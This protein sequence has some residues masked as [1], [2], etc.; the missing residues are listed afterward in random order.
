MCSDSGGVLLSGIFAIS[1]NPSVS[2]ARFKLQYCKYRRGLRKL[3]ARRSVR[4][5]GSPLFLFSSGHFYS[6]ADGTLYGSLWEPT[7]GRAEIRLRLPL[8][9][10]HTCTSSRVLDAMPLTTRRNI[11]VIDQYERWAPYVSE[12]AQDKDEL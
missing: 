3:Y 4:L 6:T 7:P 2:S 5:L 8:T 10:K 1:H 9:R 11:N 12:P